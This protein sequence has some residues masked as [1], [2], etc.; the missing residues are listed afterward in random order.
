MGVVKKYVIKRVYTI[1]Y[2]WTLKH[3]CKYFTRSFSFVNLQK[4]NK[5]FFFQLFPFHLL[6]SNFNNCTFKFLR[7]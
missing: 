6:S 5:R 4:K 2:Q 3:S 1:L 7:L